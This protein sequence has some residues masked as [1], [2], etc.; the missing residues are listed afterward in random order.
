M[1]TISLQRKILLSFVSI[2]LA[3][4]VLI[5]LIG[6]YFIKKVT[7]EKAQLEVRSGLD[8]ARTVYREQV[9]ELTKMLDLIAGS[10]NVTQYQNVLQL[11][12]IR[13]SNTAQDTNSPLV[14]AAWKGQ[15]TSG[16]RV[17]LAKDLIDMGIDPKQKANMVMKPTPKARTQKEGVLN[18]V[19]VIEA[20]IPVKNGTPNVQKVVYGGKIINKNYDL[21]DRIRDLVFDNRLYFGEPIGTVTVFQDDVRVA[22]NVLDRD[23]ERAIGTRV[24][25]EVYDAVIEGG[26]LWF[27]RAFVVSDW[28]L[29]A[30]EPLR[31]VDDNVV[32][33]L[34]VGLLEKPFVD[35]EHQILFL[36]MLIIGTVILAAIVLSTVLAT[37]IARPLNEMIIAI[38]KISEGQDPVT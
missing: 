19:L 32:G 31:D 36:F 7:V 11:D 33:I 17:L 23:G 24:S 26:S 16:T 10:D 13:V 28:Y 5:A 20:A 29:T 27:G 30:Y 9:S 8:A 14:A 21:V 34:Y 38:G 25:K 3:V 4:G 15:T 12:Y 37:S 1:K 18:D 35:M 2:V 22:T 6:L